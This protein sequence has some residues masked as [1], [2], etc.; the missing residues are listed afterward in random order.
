[1]SVFVI[2]WVVVLFVFLVFLL[3]FEDKIMTEKN[4]NLLVSI[5]TFF[6]PLQFVVNK[7]RFKCRISHVPNLIQELNAC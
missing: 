1:M 5:A 7:A 4:W 3:S 6:V 2:G